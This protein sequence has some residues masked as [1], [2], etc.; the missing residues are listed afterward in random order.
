MTALIEV[1]DLVRHFPTGGRMFKRS[2]PVRAVDGVSFA[3]QPGEVLGLVGESGSG[4]STI[5]NLVLRLDQATSGQITW[6]GD[7]ITRA[8]ER[9]LLDFRRRAQPI[10]QDP[11]GSLDPRMTVE[12][13]VG[14]PLVVH[15]LVRRVDRRARVAELLRTVGLNPD[16]LSRYPHQFSGGQRQR[17]GIARAIA[18]QP[19]LIVADEPVSALDVSIQ[20]QIINLLRDLQ[21]RMGLAM[22]FIAH[23]LAVVE[24]ISDRVAVLYLGHVMEVAP[25]ARHR[26]GPEAPLHRGLA[27]SRPGTRPGAQAAPHH[28]QRRSA[29]P[30]R[31]ALRLRVPHPLPLR[32]CRLCES[33]AG[34]APSGSR[35]PESLYPGRRSLVGRSKTASPASSDQ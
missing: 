10:F 20:A 28:P 18:M 15:R 11:F 26:A 4:K 30:D 14:E 5:G 1:V 35:T 34:V 7:D 6:R 29:Q 32:H 33:S 21:Q 9:R 13:L 12:H 17:I 22:I 27:L 2:R 16:H 31:P 23:D 8:P 19:E 25:G 24:Y 3:V